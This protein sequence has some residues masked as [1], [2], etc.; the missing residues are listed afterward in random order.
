MPYAA[1]IVVADMAGTLLGGVLARHVRQLV[2]TI[3]T[4]YGIVLCCSGL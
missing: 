3:L 4:F 2:T 1:A